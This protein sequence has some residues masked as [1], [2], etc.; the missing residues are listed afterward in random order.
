MNAAIAVDEP[1]ISAIIPCVFEKSKWLLIVDTE[2]QEILRFTS[3]KWVDAMVSAECEFLL[4]GEMHDKALFEAIAEKGITRY[5]AEGMIASTAL[6]Y[7]LNYKLPLIRDLSV[8][9]ICR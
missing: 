3:D 8:D 9:A 7:A 4:C 2:T 6:R 5:L 1:A